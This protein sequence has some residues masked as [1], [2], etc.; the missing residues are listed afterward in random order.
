[1]ATQN[2]SINVI[3]KGDSKPLDAEMKRA[4]Y[5][6]KV[7]KKQIAS[8]AGS[9]GLMFGGAMVIQGIGKAV[10]KIADFEEQMDKVAAVSR[11]SSG[12]I[13]ILRK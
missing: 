12:D 4:S 13:R 10:K 2:E 5:R 8:V 3:I 1:L 11:A 6:M 7:F 9:L